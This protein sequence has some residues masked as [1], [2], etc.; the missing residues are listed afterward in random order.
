MSCEVDDKLPVKFFKE[1]ITE[2]VEMIK[3]HLREA[4]STL[5]FTTYIGPN[6][7]TFRF[8]LSKDDK[9]KLQYTFSHLGDL[10]DQLYYLWLQLKYVLWEG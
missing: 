8:Y 3:K 5:I 7:A 9:L 6:S 1:T 10:L 4:R 2:K